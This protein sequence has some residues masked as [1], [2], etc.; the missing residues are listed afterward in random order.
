MRCLPVR[1]CVG[2]GHAHYLPAHFDPRWCYHCAITGPPWRK[3]IFGFV[4]KVPRHVAARWD[5]TELA[6]AA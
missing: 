3:V 4:R 2:C 1:R 5:E 6:R